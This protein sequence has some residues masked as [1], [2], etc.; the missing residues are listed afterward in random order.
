LTLYGGLDVGTSRVK[1]AVYDEGWRL[2]R[3]YS[4][5]APIEPRGAPRLHDAWKLRVMVSELL[6]KAG[7]LG[8]RSLGVSVYR[9]G[10]AGWRPG[11]EPMSRISLWLDVESRLEAVRSLGFRGRLLGSLPVASKLMG[12]LSPMPLIASE[13]RRLAGARVWTVDALLSEWLA[14]SYT[15]EL[16]NAVTAGLAEPFTGRRVWIVRLAGYRGRPPD[17]RLHDEPLGGGGSN[18]IGPM[19]A[20]QQSSLLASGCITRSCVKLDLGTGGFADIIASGVLGALRSQAATPFPALS[21]SNPRLHLV[22]IESMAPGIGIAV[23]AVASEVGGFGVLE[24]LDEDRC[25]SET[26]EPIAPYYP[27]TPKGRLLQSQPKGRPCSLAAGVALAVARMLLEVGGPGCSVVAVGGLSR[28]TLPLKLAATLACCRMTVYPGLD[29]SPLGAAMLA[30]YSRGDLSLRSLLEGGLR[31]GGIEFS[32][33]AGRDGLRVVEG[34]VA[35]VEG[36][37]RA[38]RELSKSVWALGGSGS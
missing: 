26:G 4:V 16:V 13:S 22:S 37:L 10:V 6:G 25:Y 32:G 19:I 33:C 38:S 31:G 9:G 15:G 14:G 8:V 7:R 2:V 35:A 29:A 27:V 36:G 5:E 18:L 11:G 23:E 12:P 3:S 30:A 17:V 20:D 24:A 28:L 21:L 1:L 34:W